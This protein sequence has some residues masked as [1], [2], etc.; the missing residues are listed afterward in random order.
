MTPLS[1]WWLTAGFDRRSFVNPFL[2]PW[3]SCRFI[4]AT[5]GNSCS[6]WWFF[7]IFFE[8]Q[9]FWLISPW[10]FRHRKHVKFAFLKAGL[11]FR[12]VCCSCLSKPS[13][14]LIFFLKQLSVISFLHEHFCIKIFHVTTRFLVSNWLAQATLIFPQET[15]CMLL[16]C[17]FIFQN[18]NL[19]MLAIATS[20]FHRTGH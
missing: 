15:S 17:L 18:M 4:L 3:F 7:P 9:W 6:L 13:G 11:F 5:F 8:V 10:V 1:D 19:K 2:T 12:W 20:R 16:S 14:P